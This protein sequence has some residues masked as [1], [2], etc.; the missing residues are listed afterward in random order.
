M[1]CAIAR[2]SIRPPPTRSPPPPISPTMIEGGYRLNVI[3]S[4]A[5]A[6]LDVRL[7]PD[8]NPDQFLAELTRVINDPAVVA[9]YITDP[10]LNRS[11]NKPS[12]LDSEVFRSIQTAVGRN[13]DTVTI[14]LL[15]TGAN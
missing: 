8:E 1:P 13:Y 6:T 15:S 7:L 5:K 12:R 14:P 3:P 11:S 4:E 10:G 2:C 9:R